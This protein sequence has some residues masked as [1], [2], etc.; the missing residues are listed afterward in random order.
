MNLKSV[1]SL[2]RVAILGL[3]CVTCI[4]CNQGDQDLEE[5]IAQQEAPPTTYPLVEES[6][7][8]Y[9]RSFEEEAADRGIDIDI[10]ALR[11]TGEISDLEGPSV[12]GQCNYNSRRPNHI[13]IDSGFWR[14]APQNVREMIVYHE[15]GHCVLY[16]GHSEATLANGICASIMR[17]GSEGC[18]DNYTSRTKSFYIDELFD[19]RQLN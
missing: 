7:W 18:R 17:S 16:R 6:L 9:F 12:A 4:S 15:L 13:S 3:I 11:I 10:N 1:I 8:S 2:E 5:L 14:F 19:N